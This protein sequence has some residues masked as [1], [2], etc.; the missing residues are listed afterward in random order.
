MGHKWDNLVV[1]KRWQLR[2]HP[3]SLELVLKKHHL[4]GGPV[5]KNLPCNAE[6]ADSIPG[7]GTKIPHATVQLS[8]RV[9]ARACEARGET[10]HDAVAASCAAT[11]T[12]D[13]VKLKKKKN[14]RPFGL[15]VCTQITDFKAWWRCSSCL[16][17]I[18]EIILRFYNHFARS[19]QKLRKG[20]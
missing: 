20:S 18:S 6:D 3:T 5:V 11:S 14:F 9:T 7:Q 13:A 4:P 12:P 16:I 2:D 19:L 17:N 8:P 1:R 15:V 10:P